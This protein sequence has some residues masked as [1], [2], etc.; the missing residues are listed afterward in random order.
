MS[1]EAMQT[2]GL[3]RNIPEGLVI[4]GFRP[5]KGVSDSNL[6]KPHE[7]ELRSYVN[8]LNNHPELIAL[9]IGYSD[10]LSH[11]K[12]N[13]PLNVS[14]ALSRA[15]LVQDAMI[16]LGAN[17]LQLKIMTHEYRDR[18][19]PQYRK[20]VVTLIEAAWFDEM[21]KSGKK[22]SDLDKK[23]DKL[24]NRIDVLYKKP[25]IFP[26]DDIC[27]TK[28]KRFRGPGSTG[29]LLGVGV[30]NSH[31]N[32]MPAIKAAVSWKR[33]IF[34]EGEVGYFPF[35]EDEFV[36]GKYRD[37]Y[38]RIISGHLAIHPNNEILGLVFGWKR[39][40]LVVKDYDRYFERREGPEVGVRLKF[41]DAVS[42][43]AL[44]SPENVDRYGREKVKWEND[45]FRFS[46]YLFKIWGG[47]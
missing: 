18:S 46:L 1:A 5:D 10:S 29:L 44:W 37:T 33:T 25:P 16:D 32:V 7:Q 11:A 41:S 45:S 43:D 26:Y 19:G 42:F 13:D 35:S 34:I 15:G 36:A 17:P 24:S 31:S 27:K 3:S 12:Y 14:D 21:Q 20:V 4:S 2:L 6:V 38:D 23:V 47:K 30:T 40:E 28:K 9:I 8:T 22:I 39:S